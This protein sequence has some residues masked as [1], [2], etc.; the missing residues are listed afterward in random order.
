M[1]V[2]RLI[3][4][5]VVVIVINSP[6]AGAQSSSANPGWSTPIAPYVSEAS[7]SVLDANGASVTL[8]TAQAPTGPNAF[9]S[10]SMRLPAAEHR[11]HRVTL[12]ADLSSTDVSGG[13][14]LWIRVD[15]ATG[16]ML[17]LDNGTADMLKGT[18][19]GS[20]S[21]TALVPADAATIVVGALL[22]GAGAMTAR[23]VRLSSSAPD[24][25]KPMSPEAAAV[26]DTAI[27]E[28]KD[29]ALKAPSVDWATVEPAVR[30]FAAGAS[31]TSD[32][33]PA[34]RYLL[35]SL[36]DRH[37]S[38]MPPAQTTEFTTGAVQNPPPDVKALPD[39][40]GYISVPGYSG[41]ELQSM[42]A[43]TRRTHE[44]LVA[45]VPS[46]ACGWVVDL[47]QDT[48]GNMWPMLGGLKPF[49]GDAGLGAFEGR[50]GKGQP[51]IAGQG[52]FIAPAATLNAL[53]KSWVAVLTGPRTVS[54]GEAVTIS[55]R[56]R[57]RTRS[58][59]QN[60]AGLS[61][62]NSNVRLPDGSM[63]LLTT[64]IEL[65]RNG[66]RYGDVITPDE[67]IPAEPA[68]AAE[69]RVLKA[70]IAWLRDSSGCAVK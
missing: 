23:N 69:D 54:S 38:L 3:V 57:P 40:V 30:A 63:M 68:G 28:V 36:G 46:V 41:G 65:D 55:F 4:V 11:L 39:R 64:A 53:E 9:G 45:T 34:I 51:W 19:T 5:L 48:G 15:S 6:Y 2:N 67:V 12:T 43:Y 20:R 49:L 32:T 27:K 60:T 26:L 59:G 61:T 21:V 13:A 25:T 50:S 58:F 62:A 37:S 29:K 52:I 31:K 7:G 33:Y 24:S 66:N 44:L 14:S 22:R 47:R 10:I 8:R 42:Q 56:G 16:A 17:S 70:A 35:S 18:A 1:R